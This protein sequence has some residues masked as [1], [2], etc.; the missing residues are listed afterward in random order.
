MAKAIEQQD[1]D[2]FEE[3]Q[4][5]IMVLLDEA[6]DIVKASGDRSVIERAKSY[7]YAHIE[8]NVITERYGGSMHNMNDTRED[9]VNLLEEEEY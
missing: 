8:G 1:I 3:I 6:L 7:W 9:L 2:R 5:D 4:Q